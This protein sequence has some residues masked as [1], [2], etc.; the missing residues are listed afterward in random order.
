M[1]DGVVLYSGLD[2]TAAIGAIT[3]GGFGPSVGGPVA[4]GY[5]TAPFSNIGTQV[6]GALR[7]KRLPLT[8]AALPFLPARFKR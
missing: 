3:S 6:F 4:M 8:V 1:R 2:D 7:G 5:V